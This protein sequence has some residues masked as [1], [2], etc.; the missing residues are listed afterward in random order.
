MGS[1]SKKHHASDV[2]VIR[3]E[4]REYNREKPL[5]KSNMK[6]AGRTDGI[7]PK[8]QLSVAHN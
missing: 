4:Q 2:K 3:D 7:R 1:T 5:G 6:Y 8:E